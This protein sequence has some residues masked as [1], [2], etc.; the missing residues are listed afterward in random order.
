MMKTVLAD[1]TA[2]NI[3]SPMMYRAASQSVAVF[4]VTSKNVLINGCDLDV[5]GNV[6][7]TTI[8]ITDMLSIVV[9]PCESKSE[10]TGKHPVFHQTHKSGYKDSEY[11][12]NPC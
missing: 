9:R 6:S 11:S 10:F 3:I 5:L 2:D 4:P 1:A 8:T 12:F 7:P